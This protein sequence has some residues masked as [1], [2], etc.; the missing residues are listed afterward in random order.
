M[1][2]RTATSSSPTSASAREK[3]TGERGVSRTPGCPASRTNQVGPEPVIAPSRRCAAS[4]APST[5]LAVPL[6]RRIPSAVT[7]PVTPSAVGA[8]AAVAAPAASAA[9]SEFS[10]WP[11]VLADLASTSPASSVGSTGPGA[12]T[13]ASCSTTTA[14]SAVVPPAPPMSSGIPIAKMPSSVSP[15]QS[16]TA[17]ASCPRAMAGSAAA[18]VRPPLV[19]SP[20]TAA[21]GPARFAHRATDSAIAICSAVTAMG[22]APP[23]APDAPAHRKLE[24]VTLTTASASPA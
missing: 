5:T 10:S 14:T 6:T 8:A 12:S 18:P 4:P 7:V 17:A 16:P 20:R 24:H 23:A 22:T 19:S 3:S 9:S 13:A 15:A 2:G 1:P 11:A 21:I